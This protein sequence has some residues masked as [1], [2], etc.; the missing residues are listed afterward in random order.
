MGACSLGEQLSRL[1]RLAV[2]DADRLPLAVRHRAHA[3][4]PAD[5]RV[6]RGSRQG[7][8]SG[9]GRGAVVVMVMVGAVVVVWDVVVIAV[10]VCLC[11][12]LS[13]CDSLYLSL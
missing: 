7:R 3:V 4:L 2:K 1:H 12:P 5:M 6:S 8:G 10:A 13:I 9:R 11:L